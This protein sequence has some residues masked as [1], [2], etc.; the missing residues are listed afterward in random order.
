MGGRENMD[1]KGIVLLVEDNEAILRTNRR[2]LEAEG[3][4]VLCAGTLCEAGQR[5]SEETPDV[6]VL[7]IMLPDGSGIEFCREIQELTAAPVLF[8]TALDEDHEIVEG[9][10]AGG[11]DYITKPYN[12][13]Q[14]VARVKA[15]LQLARRNQR[16]I[17]QVKTLKRG[18][19]T[20]EVLAGRAYLN[21]ADLLLSAKEF[22]LLRYLVQNEGYTFPKEVLYEAVWNLPAVD[23]ARVVKSHLSRVRARLQGSGYTI[24]A[25]RGKGYQFGPDK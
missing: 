21:G 16:V 19:L 9:L 15:Q 5:L 22:A 25:V 7:D 6:L 11:S 2:I 14:F 12:M 23:D 8:L 3:F 24:R 4:T 18:P 20:L 10:T 17:E 1:K 13:D